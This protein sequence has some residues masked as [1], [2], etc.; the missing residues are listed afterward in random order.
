MNAAYRTSKFKCKVKKPGNII[1]CT[2]LK[3]VNTIKNKETYLEVFMEGKLE[4]SADVELLVALAEHDFH[5]K[6]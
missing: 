5:G 3:F 6:K 4:V 1:N 2:M